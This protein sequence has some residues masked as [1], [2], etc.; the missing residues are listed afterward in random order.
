MTAADLWTRAAVRNI[1]FTTLSAD[2]YEAHRQARRW[3]RRVIRALPY[4]AAAA[5][6]IAIGSAA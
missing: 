2:S 6:I 5:V 1:G 4:I 3:R